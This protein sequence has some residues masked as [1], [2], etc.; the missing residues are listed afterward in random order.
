V[1]GVE[2][3]LERLA[4]EDRDYL[5]ACRRVLAAGVLAR[6]RAE[7]LAIDAERWPHGATHLRERI[8]SPSATGSPD[9]ELEMLD[10]GYDLQLGLAETLERLIGA[11]ARLAEA[12]LQ[13]QLDCARVRYV[14]EET[15][16]RLHEDPERFVHAECHG[17][18]L[19]RL[20]EAKVCLRGGRFDEARAVVTAFRSEAKEHASS[21]DDEAGRRAGRAS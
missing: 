7:V 16:M 1:L 13:L 17:R 3:A 6:D 2:I 4:G 9:A 11:D 8:A 20:T 21:M 12:L 14:F 18:L 19:Q 10:F 15:A 5:Q